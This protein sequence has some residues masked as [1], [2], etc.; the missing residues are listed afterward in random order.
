MKSIAGFFMLFILPVLSSEVNDFTIV[1][2]KY[3]RPINT[4]DIITGHGTAFAVDM[5]KWNLDSKH[6]LTA[7]HNVLDDDT[8]LPYKTIKLEINK[9][10]VSCIVI[11][12]EKDIDLCILKIDGNVIINQLKMADKD[13]NI[14]DNII[15][16]GSK[17]GTGIAFYN[18]I[19]TNRFEGGTAKTLMRVKFDHGDSGGPVL[20]KN[21]EVCGIAVSGIP[22]DND[23]D[24]EQ[25]LYIPIDVI[26][27]FLDKKQ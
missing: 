5:K 2:L 25:G 21:L 15:L 4:G 3:E 14:K 19:V 7:A 26:K 22:K 10:W 12:Y 16:G 27:C 23:L 18:G 8:K 11:Y 6:L 24:N 13:V 9:N 20:N 17:R 1:R